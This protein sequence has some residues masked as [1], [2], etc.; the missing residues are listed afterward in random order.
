MW[1]AVGVCALSGRWSASSCC[2]PVAT[3]AR[4][5][6]PFGLDGDPVKAT[7]ESVTEVPCSFD[8]L[9]ACKLVERSWSDGDDRGERSSRAAARLAT[10]SAGDGILVDLVEL[11]DGVGTGRLLRLRAQHADAAAG[12][13]VR[14]VDRRARPVARGRGARRA[15]DELRGDH[16]VRAAGT[17]RGIERGRGRDRHRRGDRVRRAVPRARPRPGHR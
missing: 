11:G 10:I 1:V 12:D 6:D 14:G 16:R 5:R 2:G 15:G 17:A 13:R 3:T 7:A 8:P 9:L 4:A